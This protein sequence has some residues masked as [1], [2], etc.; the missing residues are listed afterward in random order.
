MTHPLN[1]W[2]HSTIS[3]LMLLV[4]L[5]VMYIILIMP[6]VSGRSDVRERLEELQFQFAKFDQSAKQIQQL[7]KELEQLNNL[8]ADQT[9]FLEEKPDALAAAEL[10][11]HIKSLIESNGGN[12]IS[13][14]VVKNDNDDL[15]PQ[16]TIKVHMR[17]EIGTLQKILYRLTV[18]SPVLLI[19]NVMLQKRHQAAGRRARRGV[20]QIETRFEITGFIFQAE[21][22]ET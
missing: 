2:Q 7:Q 21:I 3:V 8:Q 22:A 16:V 9:G 5:L 15:F 17:G 20:N 11:K 18:D 13:T 10:Q 19:N 12:L 1:N 4:C 6:A 14:Q